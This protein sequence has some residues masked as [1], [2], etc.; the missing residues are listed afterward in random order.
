MDKSKALPFHLLFVLFG[1]TN[2]ISFSQTDIAPIVTASGNQA[3][4]S[5]NP[6]NIVTN[7]T[8]TDADDT[9]IPSFFIQISSGYQVNLD[10]LELTGNHPNISTNWNTN[11]GKLTLTSSRGGEMLLTDVENAVRNVQFRTSAI[12]ITNTKT[13]SLSIDNANYLPST[14]HFYEFVDFPNITWS[15]ARI[16]AENRF[17][18]GR[19]GYLATLTS[20]EEANFAGKQASGAGWIGGSDEETEGVWKWVTGPEAGEVFWNGQINGSSPPGAFAFWNNNEPNN[21]RG[22]NPNGEHYAHI[23]DPSI[24][25]QGAWNDLPNEGGTGLYIPRGYIVEYGKPTDPPLSITASTSI[26][27]PAVT[28]VTNAT[29]C[30]SETATISATSNE[31]TILWY[32]TPTGDTLL[33]SGNNFTTPALTNSRPFYASVSVNGCTTNTR[34][35]VQVAVVQKPTITAITEDLICSGN[36]T[37]SAQSSNGEVRW[38]ENRTSTTPIFIGNTYETPTLNATTSYFVEA[39]NTTCAPSPRIEVKA[40][41]D[42]T[43]PQFDLVETNY[44]LCNDLGSVTLETTNS[45][46]NYTYVWSKDGN[47][48]PG[49][50]PTNEV[51]ESGNYTV[52]AVSMSGCESLTQN[53]I[54]TDS[55]KAQITN[56]DISI[57]DTSANKSVTIQMANLGI[58]D[59]EF[60]LDDITGPYTSRN[61]FD[62]LSLGIHIIYIRDKRGCGITSYSF[63]ILGFPDFFSPNDDG[64]NDVWGINGFNSS[65]FTTSDIY[66]YNR[67]GVLIH[68]INPEV[69]NWDGKQNGKLLPPNT[70]WYRAIFI[71]TNN[72]KIEKIGHFS[73]I[74]N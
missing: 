63:S 73:L 67:F 37:L 41:V 72:R 54:V 30:E 22:N 25:I 3:F 45:L 26:Y 49:N 43:I 65:A 21:F 52:K 51:R 42:N 2:L 46:G 27:I 71:D 59:Y 19:K 11:E 60:A 29:I 58:G 8:L 32:D 36:A 33:G 55:E 40:T 64:K 44:P 16:A 66:I 6:I 53:I 5:G 14:D 13:F 50:L 31:G 34:T 69:G 24:G 47:P 4:C 28:N 57:D 18:Y 39:H 15:D 9:A 1:F 7:F 17:F 61:T 48:I 20:Q 12:N 56:E 23:T 62:N 10:I 74:Q 35:P 68:K 70:Y 38:F